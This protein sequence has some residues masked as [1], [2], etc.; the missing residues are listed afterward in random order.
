MEGQPASLSAHT[1]PAVSLLG[2]DLSLPAVGRGVCA[3]FRVPGG[4][5]LL[6]AV[7][8]YRVWG[9][10]GSTLHALPLE[11]IARVGCCVRMPLSHLCL[12]AQPFAVHPG[13][14]ADYFARL[15]GRL[16]GCRALPGRAGQEGGGMKGG[17]LRRCSRMGGLNVIR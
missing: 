17:N 13:R 3:G 16:A 4:R 14:N 10:I 15:S 8:A 1:H 7:C 9:V 2:S 12:S 5:A 6:L 11:L